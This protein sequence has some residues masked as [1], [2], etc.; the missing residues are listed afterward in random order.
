MARKG[1][2]PA[3]VPPTLL[4]DSNRAPADQEGREKF[5]TLHWCLSPI[6]KDGK[7]VRQAG[8]VKMRVVGGYY[9]VT[10][11][12]VSEQRETT[13]TTDTLVGLCEQLERHLTAPG[14]I[15]FPDW[16]ATKRSR[17]EAKKSLS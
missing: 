10:V 7:C 2:E 9:L 1:D 17:Q 5:P 13:M 11:R 6:W 14:T 4:G 12:C 15:W 16:S 8:E 3:P